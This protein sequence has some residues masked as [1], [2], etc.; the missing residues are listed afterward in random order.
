VLKKPLY[1]VVSMIY[2]LIL[3]LPD[4]SDFR[5]TI[6]DFLGKLV[7][8]IPKCNGTTNIS[9]SDFPK[10]IYAFKISSATLL[11]VEKVIKK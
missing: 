3:F 2:K 6:Y 8:E 7:K 1:R 9:L 10:G 11:S 5:V 4:N